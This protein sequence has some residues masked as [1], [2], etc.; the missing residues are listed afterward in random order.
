MNTLVLTLMFT[1][2]TAQY[3]L[4][5]GLLESLCFVESAHKVAAVHY[6]DGGTNSVGICQ[7]KLSTAKGLGYVG[8]EKGLYDARTNIN[9]AAKYL[10]KQIK[11]YNS[12]TKGIIAYNV[13]HAG[14][15]Q[16]TQYSTKV[17]KQWRQVSGKRRICSTAD[18]N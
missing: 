12:T 8:T 1:Q 4:P 7:I 11:R 6:D 18:R 15:F 17:I 16:T 5:A 10:A 3:H 2:A 9:Y 14:N 13:G